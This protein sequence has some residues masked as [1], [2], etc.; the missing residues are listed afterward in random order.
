MHLFI[1]Q[2]DILYKT[3]HPSIQHPLNKYDRFLSFCTLQ[4]ALTFNQFNPFTYIGTLSIG[5]DLSFSLLRLFFVIEFYHN[6]IAWFIVI[7]IR[8]LDKAMIIDGSSTTFSLQLQQALNFTL[9]RSLFKL[10]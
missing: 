6:K 4:L 10:N 3:I 9:I 1:V 2:G 8:G 5:I 7:N